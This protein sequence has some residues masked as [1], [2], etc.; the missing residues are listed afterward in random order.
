MVTMLYIQ[1]LQGLIILLMVRG[2]NSNT[3]GNNNT[4]SGLNSLYSNTTGSNNTANGHRALYSNTTGVGNVA[5]GVNSFI[6]KH[7]RV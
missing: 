1:T 7:Y 4:A 5:N 3:T 2:F 6:L